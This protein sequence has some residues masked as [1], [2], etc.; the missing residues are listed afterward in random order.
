MKAATHRHDQAPSKV[1][2][3]AIAPVAGVRVNGRIVE[4]ENIARHSV[5]A[6]SSCPWRSWP[7]SP[8]RSSNR[9]QQAAFGMSARQSV[10][11]LAVAAIGGLISFSALSQLYAPVAHIALNHLALW[12]RGKLLWLLEVGPDR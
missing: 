8:A 7:I 12:A 5:R 6:A 4:V 1:A 2:L 3:L 9:L 11:R 10:R